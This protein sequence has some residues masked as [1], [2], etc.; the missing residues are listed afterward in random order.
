MGTQGPFAHCGVVERVEV[1]PGDGAIQLTTI[2]AL[3]RSGVTRTGVPLYTPQDGHH[4]TL[5]SIVAAR[6]D[7]LGLIAYEPG[8]PGYAQAA[9]PETAALAALEV[10]AS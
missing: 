7:V 1:S 8:D 4:R 3:S 6:P 10:V 2:E 5:A 9:A